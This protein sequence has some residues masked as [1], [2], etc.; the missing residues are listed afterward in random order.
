MFRALIVVPILCGGT[1]LYISGSP[2]IIVKNAAFLFNNSSEA[3]ISHE[4]TSC[5]AFS[6]A[7]FKIILLIV[8]AFHLI[9]TLCAPKSKAISVI[10]STN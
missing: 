3:L 1:S 5:K 9:Y 4:G 2:P 8:S 7:F 6:E 10:T